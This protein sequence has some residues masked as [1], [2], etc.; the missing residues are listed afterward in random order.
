MCTCS[1]FAEQCTGVD[2]ASG[3]VADHD[4]AG[5]RHR[6]HPLRHAHLLTDG[7]VG[8]WARTDFAGDDL[9]GVQPDAK[10]QADVVAASTSAAK[11]L[12]VGL[13]VQCGA[14][15]AYRVVLEGDRRAE[16]RHDPVAGELV[17]RAAVALDDHR[18]AAEHLA[19]DLAQPFRPDGR[20]DIHR[21]DHVGEQHGDLLVLGMTVDGGDGRSA[22]VTEPGA[23]PQACAARTARY[24]HRSIVPSK[25]KPGLL[26][27]GL[28][29]RNAI[30]RRR[31]SR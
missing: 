2:K 8:H 13:D 23:V 28:T 16:H 19:H 14:A 21:V 15:G 18:R 22:R 20:R 25:E 29:A 7:G 3:R 12:R 26:N 1:G 17:H 24:G 6:L 27:R 11:C 9:T 4:P 30:S 5:R 10:L 31:A